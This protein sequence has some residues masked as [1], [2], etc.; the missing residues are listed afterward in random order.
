VFLVEDFRPTAFFTRNVF[1]R[2]PDLLPKEITLVHVKHRF[3]VV[4]LALI[5]LEVAMSLLN[6]TLM[7]GELGKLF[8]AAFVIESASGLTV[9]LRRLGSRALALS[10]KYPGKRQ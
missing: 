8:G 5:G 6:L 1:L 7:A 9:S 4:H 3:Q 2:D 10:R